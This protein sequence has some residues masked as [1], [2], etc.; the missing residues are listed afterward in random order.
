M[1]TFMHFILSSVG[2]EH[3]ASLCSPYLAPLDLSLSDS[4]CKALTSL[5]ETL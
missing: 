5:N 1:R 2:L 4:S 3:N